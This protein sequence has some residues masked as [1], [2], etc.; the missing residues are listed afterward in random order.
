MQALPKIN[1]S[2][3]IPLPGSLFL[4]TAVGIGVLSFWVVHLLLGGLRWDHIAGGAVFLILFFGGKRT[5]SLFLFF[6]PF[7]LMLAVYDLQ[8]YFAA[9]LRPAAVHLEEPYRFDLMWFGIDGPKGRMI[10]SRWLQEHTHP[11]LDFITGLAYINFV[12]VFLL[13]AFWFRFGLSRWSEQHDSESQRRSV[14]ALMWGMLVLNIACCSVYYVY[15]AA[16]PWYIDRYGFEL[17]TD[18]QPDPAGGARFDALT[19]TTVYA[20]YYSRTPNVF[21][22]VPSIHAAFPLLTLYFAFRLKSLRGF[23]IFFFLLINFS[24]LYLNHHF[25]FDLIAGWIMALVVAVAA[26]RL[27]RA[28]QSEAPLRLPVPGRAA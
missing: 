10:P 5:R 6:L 16:P 14:N 3:T 15:P 18:V 12:P 9:S 19:G 23:S 26:D 4:K 22:A 8:A 25:I 20:A 24:A 2:S 28:T 7:I 17:L 13:S 21:G 1:P 27:A 11:G